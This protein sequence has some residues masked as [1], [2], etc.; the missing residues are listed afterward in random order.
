MHQATEVTPPGAGLASLQSTSRHVRK[1]A[2]T[3]LLALIGSDH[4]ITLY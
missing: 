4:S 1:Q 3:Y 2:N